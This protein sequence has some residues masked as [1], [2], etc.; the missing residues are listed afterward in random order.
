MKYA[1]AALAVVTLATALVGAVYWFKSSKVT[2]VPTWAQLGLAE[3]GDES[4]SQ[5]AWL[6]ATLEAASK[7]A[8]LNKSA[9][10]WTGVAAILGAVTTAASLF[11]PN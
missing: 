9:A 6:A 7:S 8:A 10:V 3:P 5:M 11:I 2:A 4:A 1:V